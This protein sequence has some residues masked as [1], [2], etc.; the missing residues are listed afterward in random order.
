[1]WSQAEGKCASRVHS[2]P[3]LRQ[4]GLS[5]QFRVLTIRVCEREHGEFTELVDLLELQA[6]LELLGSLYLLNVFQCFETIKLKIIQ[7]ISAYLIFRICGIY[8]Q[9]SCGPASSE[10]QIEF[11]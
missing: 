7:T 10:I 5:K 8:G 6:A 1:M 3:S 11:R 2:G 9:Q 4:Y